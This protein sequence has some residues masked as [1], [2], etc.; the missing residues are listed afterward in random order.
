M[1]YTAKT[2]SDFRSMAGTLAEKVTGELAKLE[3][4]LS[5]RSSTV[6]VA[7]SDS[8]SNGKAQ[9]DYVCDGTSDDVELRTAINALP[10]TGGDIRLLDGTFNLSAI[11]SRAIDNVTISGVGRSTYLKYNNSSFCISLGTQSNW[12]IKDLR[13]DQGGIEIANAKR[14]N[15]Q[16]VWRDTVY[17]SWRETH[18]EN[19]N[20]EHIGGASSAGNFQTEIA[21]HPLVSVLDTFDVSDWTQ[22]VGTLTYDT[23][24]K[25]DGNQSA[26]LVSREGATGAIDKNITGDFTNS[27]ISMWMQTPDYTKIDYISIIL[28]TTDTTF[29][30]SLRSDSYSIQTINNQWFL[31]NFP[32]FPLPTGTPDAANVMSVR[33]TITPKSGQTA[34]A[35]FDTL[36]TW[37]RGVLTPKGAVVFSFDDGL[38]TTYNLARPLMDKYGYKGVNAVIVS[39]LTETDISH[40]KYMQSSGWDIVS[41]SFHHDSRALSDPAWEYLLAQK[42]LADNGFKS[43]SRFV[44]LYG[45]LHNEPLMKYMGS[46]VLMTRGGF[47]GLLSL[48]QIGDL[49]DIQS[50]KATDTVATVKSMIDAAKTNGL[51]LELMFHGISTGTPVDYEYSVT[52]LETLIDYCNS[53]GVE[54]LTY[55]DIVERIRRRTISVTGT[56]TI[57]SGSTSVNLRHGFSKTPTSIQI[58]PT[59]G[60]GSAS[61]I[62]MSSKDTGTGNLFTVSVDV[63]PGQDVTFDWITTL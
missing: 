26:K 39:K 43:G 20:E 7:A 13:V 35:Y 31:I 55:S 30:H 18:I 6:V 34:T 50:C 54:V 8:S 42:W 9:A 51:A 21:R 37:K 45:G 17:P 25:H 63:D 59:S 48:P 57:S 3:K 33:I 47:R 38:D 22:T 58:I 11:L 46:H 19:W 27:S 44:I 40:N 60:L 5:P 36:H 52:D 23:D 1:T 24:I 62:W 56:G 14:W 4:S 29:A 61:S 12:T 49:Q 10:S 41:H 32:R 15:I 28:S 53:Q 2:V 16:N